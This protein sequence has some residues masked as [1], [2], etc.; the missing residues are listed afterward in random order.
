MGG[1]CIPVTGNGEIPRAIPSQEEVKPPVRLT[2]PQQEDV[3]LPLPSRDDL[4]PVTV[5]V[6]NI[7]PV[8]EEQTTNQSKEQDEENGCE[9]VK[10]RETF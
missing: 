1:E 6:P 10:K 5:R 9:E 8:I 2:C 3:I 7:E 4:H